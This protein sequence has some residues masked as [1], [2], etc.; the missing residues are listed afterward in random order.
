MAYFAFAYIACLLA[1]LAAWV[2]HVVVC[3]KSASYLFL[4]AGAVL[5]PVGVIHG[6]GVWLGV[7]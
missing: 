5:P 2:T 7:W 6:W 3:I 4:I 1:A